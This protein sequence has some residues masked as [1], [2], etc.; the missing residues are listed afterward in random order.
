MCVA[1]KNLFAVV[2][3]SRDQTTRSKSHV[4]AATPGVISAVYV[5][6]AAYFTLEVDT[7]SPPSAANADFAFTLVAP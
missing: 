3:A 6:Q 1:G 7:T 2:V 4:E 5:R